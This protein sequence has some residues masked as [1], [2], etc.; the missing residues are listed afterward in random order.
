MGDGYDSTGD[1][2]DNIEDGYR[3]RW[4]KIPSTHSNDGRPAWGHLR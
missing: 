1:G 2:Y 4:T 3:G